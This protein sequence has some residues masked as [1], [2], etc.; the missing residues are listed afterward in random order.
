M[1]LYLLVIYD[2]S[3]DD[4]RNKVSEFLKSRGLVRVQRSAYI[5]PSTTALKR[6][7]ESGL[8]RL[9]GGRSGVNIQVFL[10]TGACYKTRSLIGDVKYEWDGGVVVT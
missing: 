2:I 5:G 9:V 8:A 6:E 7:V 3:D 10:L 4:L 1:E